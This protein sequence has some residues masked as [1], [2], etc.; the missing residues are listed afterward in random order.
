MFD[1]EY[2]KINVLL[3]SKNLT[4]D[5]A[6]LSLVDTN[7]TPYGAIK[8]SGNIAPTL[9]SFNI[10]AKNSASFY[11]RIAMG[12][13]TQGDKIAGKGELY[14]ARINYVKSNET[15]YKESNDNCATINFYYDNFND[16]TSYNKYDEDYVKDAY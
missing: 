15:E 10:K 14:I 5:G 7:G 2:Y 3:A 1:E 4:K 11:V 6:T 13:N 16:F 12:D 8:L 9:Y